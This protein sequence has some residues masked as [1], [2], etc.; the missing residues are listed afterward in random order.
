MYYCPSLADT[1]V[2]PQHFT[3]PVIQD[4][5]YNEYCLID[6]PGYCRI[7]L[8]PSHDNDASFI[9]LQKSNDLYTIAGYAP[10]SYE[11]HVSR[12]ATKPQLLSELW[13]Q[14]LGHPGPK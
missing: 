10:S 2:S 6:L 12:L 9:T 13:H 3:S 7:L 1:I 5:C 4:R 8:S 11:P 14:R